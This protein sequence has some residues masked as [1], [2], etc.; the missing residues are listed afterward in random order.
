MAEKSTTTHHWLSNR[1]VRELRSLYTADPECA[2]REF[3]ILPIPPPSPDPER[4]QA[5]D[6]WRHGR[7]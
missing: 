4:E 5:A 1:K 3:G 7:N 2:I 6:D